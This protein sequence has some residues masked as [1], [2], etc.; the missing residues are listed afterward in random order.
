M[1]H[2][3]RYAGNSFTLHSWLLWVELALLLPSLLGLYAVISVVRKRSQK[4]VTQNE[5]LGSPLS[6]RSLTSTWLILERRLS[7]FSTAWVS[8][9]LKSNVKF[10]GSRSRNGPAV[11]PWTAEEEARVMAEQIRKY[12]N[13]GGYVIW[14]PLFFAAVVGA[15]LTYFATH[16]KENPTYEYRN[17]KVL[18]RVGADSWWIEREDGPTLW[19]CCPDFNCENVI[20]AGYVM[21]K[22]R[23]EDF[24]TC[25]S[26][27]RP[28]LGVWWD[29]DPITKNVKEIDHANGTAR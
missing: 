2:W 25:K 27:L 11:R 23:Y 17:V 24:G 13:H 7:N 16:I 18:A 22:F 19:N 6:K 21:R 4:D 20:Q 9:R 10:L 28:D 12:Q 15:A 26:I 3:V 5:G 14:W 29:R 1:T 8:W